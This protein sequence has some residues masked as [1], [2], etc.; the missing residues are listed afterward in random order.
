MVM[1]G[2]TARRARGELNE[3]EANKKASKKKKKEEKKR[4][5]Q[6]NQRVLRHAC[7]SHDLVSLTFF[8]NVR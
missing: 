4:G 2:K 3:E 1:K 7:V 5:E 8:Q 6:P